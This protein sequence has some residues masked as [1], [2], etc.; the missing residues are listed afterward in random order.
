MPKITLFKYKRLCFFDEE[1]MDNLLFE[2]EDL[3]VEIDNK[4]EY[5]RGLLEGILV[6]ISFL[7]LYLA[8]RVFYLKS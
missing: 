3:F 2:I 8:I 6:V 1:R 4:R 5:L 7:W